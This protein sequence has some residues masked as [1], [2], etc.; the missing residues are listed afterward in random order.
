[1]ELGWIAA[2]DLELRD[3]VVARLTE[4][5]T[6]AG[7]SPEAEAGYTSVDPRVQGVS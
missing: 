3:D 2:G 4:R 1:M 6:A 5:V 7:F